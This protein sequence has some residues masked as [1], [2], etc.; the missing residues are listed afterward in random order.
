MNEQDQDIFFNIIN[1]FVGA[2]SREASRATKNDTS[3][4]YPFVAMD[5]RQVFEQIRFV[6]QH[7][8]IDMNEINNQNFKF[9]DVGCG[10][11]NILLIAEQFG[12]DVYGIEKD[13]YPFQV[14][15]RLIGDD[16]ISQDDIWTYDRYNVYDVIYYFRPFSDREPQLRFEKLI[17][18]NLKVGGILIANHK[19]S[20]GISADK[21]FEKLS[22]NLPIWQKKNS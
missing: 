8:Q 13:E 14:A 15:T 20:D 1:R 7:L 16:Q 5:T 19:N 6:A 12:F 17:E 11:G 22:E 21:R 10:I 3:R 18:D 2:Y 9:I 4:E